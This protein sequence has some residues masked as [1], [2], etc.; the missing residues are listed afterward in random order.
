MK[1][2]AIIGGDNQKGYNKKFKA[3]H[4]EVKYHDGRMK[5]TGV[6][7]YFRNLL[8]DVDCVILIPS[9]VS[10]GTMYAVKE[11]ATDLGIKVVYQR[12]KGISGVLQAVH[13]NVAF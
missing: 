9:A 3:F 12:S 7:N 11:V 2:I 8:K 1:K 13:D 10:H 5:R 4:C 6:K